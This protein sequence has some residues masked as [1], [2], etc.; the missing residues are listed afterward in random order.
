MCRQASLAIRNLVV[1]N[2]EL[3]QVVLEDPN[4][5]MQLRKAMPL[6]GCGDE[7]Y[8]ALRDLGADIPI[9][10][11]AQSQA[12]FNPVMESSN[13]LMSTIQENAHAPFEDY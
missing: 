4:A 2:P 3:R 10:S 6:R 7:A 13:Q 8:A 5:E 11:I 12:N 1:R 9:A